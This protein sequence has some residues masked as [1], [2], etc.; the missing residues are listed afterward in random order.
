MPTAVEHL[1]TDIIDDPGPE[2]STLY[3]SLWVDRVFSPPIRRHNVVCQPIGKQVQNIHVPSQCWV[4]EQEILDYI[5]APQ[6]VMIRPDTLEC[7]HDLIHRFTGDIDNYHVLPKPPSE[8]FDEF[9]GISPSA[10]DFPNPF[11]KREDLLRE[12]T[13]HPAGVVLKGQPG[14]GEL[15]LHATPRL[16]TY[17]ILQG[18]VLC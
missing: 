10:Q 11:L 7:I 14:I 9:G 6:T 8:L 15:L 18:K 12:D 13:G 16:C 5:G 1:F 2:F 3:H 4:I 17:P